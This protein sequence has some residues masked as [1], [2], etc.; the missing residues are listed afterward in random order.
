MM[1][2]DLARD[3]KVLGLPWHPRRGDV[4][5]DRLNDPFL[6]LADGTDEAGGV[7]IDIR[8][9]VERRPILGLTWIPRLD[10]LSAILARAGRV[11]VETSPSE[12]GR[13]PRAWSVTVERDGE[14]H[15]FLATDGAQAAALALHYLMTDA[16]W[17]P[18][19]PLRLDEV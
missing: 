7:Q 8:R 9:G 17:N 18:G 2:M 11:V 10:Q 5:M 15:S 19:S 4:C 13:P 6:V 16:G 1:S 14:P 3:L 12:P